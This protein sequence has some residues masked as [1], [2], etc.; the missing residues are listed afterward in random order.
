MLIKWRKQAFSQSDISGDDH[1]VSG[2]KKREIRTNEY[3][4]KGIYIWQGVGLSTINLLKNAT[5]NNYSIEFT[6]NML[7][8]LQEKGFFIKKKI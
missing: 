8:V 7:L 2:R 3:F 6:S 1:T 4:C 5:V